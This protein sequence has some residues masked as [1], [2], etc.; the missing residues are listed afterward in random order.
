M[1]ARDMTSH[2]FVTGGWR[3]EIL[4]NATPRSQVEEQSYRSKILEEL[5]PL[6]HFF[7][8]QK[9]IFKS[10][11]GGTAVFVRFETFKKFE[12]YLRAAIMID[13]V[14]L[15][16][17][18]AGTYEDTIAQFR[19]QVLGFPMTST[20]ERQKEM[21]CAFQNKL[22]SALWW[23]I[24]GVSD[25]VEQQYC[26]VLTFKKQEDAKSLL[27]ERM[28]VNNYTVLSFVP[29]QWNHING[30]KPTVLYQASKVI[31][32]YVVLG[33]NLLLSN[34]NIV[35]FTVYAANDITYVNCLTYTVENSTNLP[36]LMKCEAIILKRIPQQ[37]ADVIL[38]NKAT[39]VKF[40]KY[41]FALYMQQAEK[42]CSRQYGRSLEPPSKTLP[43]VPVRVNNIEEKKMWPRPCLTTHA[44]TNTAL[45][46]GDDDK[47]STCTST[48]SKKECTNESPLPHVVP[49]TEELQLEVERLR[50]V[51]QQQTRLIMANEAGFESALADKE[52]TLHALVQ[53]VE[54]L[55]LMVSGM[56]HFLNKY[57]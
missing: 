25:K 32:S 41:H 12:F 56:K 55:E 40:P 9:V 8:N 37:E 11:P 33:R 49:R 54:K 52:R 47:Q 29:F 27:N 18:N 4:P 36:E 14:E 34:P 10:M 1:S 57:T 16:F 53:R 20:L 43:V 17:I 38:N 39:Y 7:H 15:R 48:P 46:E 31:D 3:F 51:V 45:P 19:V 5:Q 35:S 24:N 2:G 42:V 30:M 21:L 26:K 50:E 22:R 28:F 44:A 6:L 23:D 13:G